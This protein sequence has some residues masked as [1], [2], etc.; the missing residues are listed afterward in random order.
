MAKEYTGIRCEEK[1][2]MILIRGYAPI[3]VYQKQGNLR[4]LLSEDKKSY[5]AHYDYWN[6]GAEMKKT[7]AAFELNYQK[8]AAAAICRKWGFTV[9]TATKTATGERMIAQM[10]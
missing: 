2:G 5:E 3:E 4:F 6:C 1:D 8:A 9:G 10:W 7:I